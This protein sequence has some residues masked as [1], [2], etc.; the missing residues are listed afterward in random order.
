MVVGFDFDDEVTDGQTILLWTAWFSLHLNALYGNT[1]QSC[2]TGAQGTRNTGT[3]C[4]AV[5]LVKVDAP[6]A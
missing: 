4:D 1:E 3:S 5:K 6:A 2:Y